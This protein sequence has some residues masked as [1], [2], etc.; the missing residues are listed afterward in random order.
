VSDGSLRAPE[1]GL[2][3]SACAFREPSTGGL[4]PVV[5]RW[6]WIS[7]GLFLQLIGVAGP[8][9]YLITKAKKEDVGGQLTGV[10]V[11]LAWH[12]AVHARTGLTLLLVGALVFAAGATLLARPFV[13][14][15]R[16]LLV[17]VPVAA[18]AGVLV[19]GVG[20]LLLAAAV[21]VLGELDFLGGW[22]DSCF[23]WSDSNSNRPK[24]TSDQDD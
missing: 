1:K 21:A 24:K 17:A 23:D 8:A 5:R 7:G 11:R 14:S 2:E 3:E 4:A 15:R 12:Q 6:P 19:L 9:T 18:I 16:M 20:A 10:T 22:G 13:K